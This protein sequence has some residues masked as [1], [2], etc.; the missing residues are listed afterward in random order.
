MVLLW[1]F[2]NKA[3]LNSNKFCSSTIKV[4][5]ITASTASFTQ[6]K[7]LRSSS[8]AV[9]TRTGMH[10]MNSQSGF[11]DWAA[12]G[13]VW[14]KRSFNKKDVSSVQRSVSDTAAFFSQQPRWRGVLLISETTT[15][16]HHSLA[17]RATE[18]WY[19]TAAVQQ[20]CSKLLRLYNKCIR[21]DRESLRSYKSG[22]SCQRAAHIQDIKHRWEAQLV[23]QVFR[24]WLVNGNT[25]SSPTVGSHQYNGNKHQT[26]AFL[27]T[28]HTHTHKHTQ[29]HLTLNL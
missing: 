11:C 27:H 19:F 12:P 22:A 6:E 8:D 20:T 1:Y 10:K 14:L 21:G 7:A 16:P 13:N 26:S 2:G 17:R 5:T 25:P 15:A 3:K 29:L 28:A 18:G 24:V 9:E 4:G 23:L